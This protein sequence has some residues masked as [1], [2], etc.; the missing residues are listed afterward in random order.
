M[1]A[2]M[3]GCLANLLG[4]VRGGLS[5]VLV[6]AMYLVSGISGAKAADMAAA[7]PVL[8]PEMARRGVRR[9]ELM[10][11]L[12]ATGAQTETVPPI[13]IT[14]GSVM[15]VSITSLLSGGLLP[16]LVMGLI[17]C[18]V[19]WH[20]AR[21]AAVP[22]VPR[23]SAGT[24]LRSLA[25]ALPFIIRGRWSA[26]WRRRRRCPPSAS[27][28]QRSPDCW[29][30]SGLTGGASGRCL[31]QTVALSGA[32]LLIV[33]AATATG[34]AATQSGV[35]R[36]LAAWLQ[37]VPGGA[38]VF[39]AV[40]AVIFIVLG[41]KLEGIPAIVLMGPLLFPLARQ[42]GIH[43]VHDAMVA[44]LSMVIG[45][46]APPFGVGHDT[47][48]AISGCSPDEEM[49]FIGRYLLALVV[50]VGVIAV[51]PWLSIEVL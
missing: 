16:G 24:I 26:A 15:G 12:A 25:L 42:L 3:A 49:R 10:A 8:F 17:L 50:G 27:P 51:L 20:G 35:S 31:V 45:L 28:M 47:A 40:S 43:E 18:A 9:G 30:A 5:Y 46:F 39:M 36:N 11:L 34:W 23:A 21:Q 6:G 41:S 19:V 48:C 44:I 38:G 1:A 32:I 13:L 2:V 4:H 14:I 37:S 33:G 29:C 7:V 22:T